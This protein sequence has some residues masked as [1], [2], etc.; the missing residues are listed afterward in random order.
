MA[1][2]YADWKL[3]WGYKPSQEWCN[4]QCLEYIKL[5]VVRVIFLSSEFD[6]VTPYCVWV[7]MHENRGTFK[8]PFVE[9]LQFKMA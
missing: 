4:S 6:L 8:L 2:P 3:Q 7:T 5:S 9:I 1:A